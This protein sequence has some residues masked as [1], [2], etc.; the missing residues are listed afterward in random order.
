MQPGVDDDDDQEMA[1]EMSKQYDD[2]GDG[3]NE[4]A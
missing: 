2:D 4:D 1:H 3:Q